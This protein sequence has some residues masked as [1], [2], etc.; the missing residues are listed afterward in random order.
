MRLGMK[1]VALAQIR[2]MSKEIVAISGNNS[3]DVG[4]VLAIG[5]A[6]AYQAIK[7]VRELNS[8]LRAVEKALPSMKSG[9]VGLEETE[10]QAFETLYYNRVV[11]PLFA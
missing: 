11:Q 1:K 5:Q 4:V 9:M 6:Q 7:S 8:M 3:K 10:W 2:A